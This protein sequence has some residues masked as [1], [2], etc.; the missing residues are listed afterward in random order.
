[1]GDTESARAAGTREGRDFR[2]RELRREKGLHF[3]GV[4]EMMAEVM[5]MLLLKKRRNHLRKLSARRRRNHHHCNHHHHKPQ[6]Q[7]KLMTPHISPPQ[8]NLNPITGPWRRLQE[9]CPQGHQGD[10]SL[11]QQGNGYR[12][13][14]H[15]PPAKQGSLEVR[16]QG[17]PIPNPRPHHPQA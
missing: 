2:K 16:H 15:R 7:P 14:P 5:E 1:M 9:A 4:K 13:R 11:R 6:P 10:Q 17:R 8:A 3:E 12:G